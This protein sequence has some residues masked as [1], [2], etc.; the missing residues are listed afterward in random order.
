MTSTAIFDGRIVDIPDVENPPPELAAGARNFLVTGYRA[1]TTMPMMR[2]DLSIG[3]LTVARR[4]P[5]PLSDKQCAVLKTFAD[6]AVIAIENTPL[7]NELRESLQQQTATADVLQV[8]SASPGSS[9]PYSTHCC[10]MRYG[11]APANSAIFT[12][13]TASCSP[14]PRGTT[15]RL[16][17]WN[18]DA[19][20]PYHPGA[21]SPPGRMLRTKS[22]VHVVDLLTDASYAERDLGVIA[23]AELAGIRT[24][25]LVPMLKEGEPIGYLSVYRQ[26]VQPFS[27]KQIELLENF[28]AQ[29]VIAIENTRLLNELR[30]SLQQ[31]TATADVL[32]VISRSAFDLHSVLDTLVESAARVC[33]AD[34]VVLARP[35]DGKYRFEATFG[36]SREYREFVAS[37]PPGIDR[38][39]ATGRTLVDG[40]ITHIPDVLADTEYTYTEGQKIGRYRTLLAV[41]LLPEGT[42]IGVLSLQ[43]KAVRP[44]TDKQ[45]GAR[46]CGDGGAARSAQQWQHPRPLRIRSPLGPTAPAALEPILDADRA[47]SVPAGLRLDMFALRHAKL[48]SRASAQQR[49]ATT[50]T[51]RR[52][53]AS[54]S[55]FDGTRRASRR[56]F[57]SIAPR[58]S[59]RSRANEQIQSWPHL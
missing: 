55:Y 26:E 24:I 42:P 51:P 16:I 32:K 52:G 9:S 59:Q 29:A 38:G 23:G 22:V 27:D 13:V 20:S 31:Q 12:C 25:V 34:M 49:A 6:Q 46:D 10:R 30:E 36:A 3:A 28:A 43:C 57:V 58:R 7:L 40:K 44:F 18:I 4:A 47:L 1:N 48:L 39:T 54:R 8:I 37:H 2:G 5:G 11:C 53:V 56:R 19:A 14:S 41:P 35:K 15:R 33:E 21:N 17:L 50:Q 45:I